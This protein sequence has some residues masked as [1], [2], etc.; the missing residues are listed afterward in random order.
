MIVAFI[1]VVTAL[2]A[3]IV[4]AA[5]RTGVLREKYAALW[6]LVAAGVLVLAIWPGL[7]SVV[8]DWFGVVVPSNLLFAVAILLL[9]AVSLQLSLAVSTLESHTRTL[10]EEVSLLR[11]DL[12]E[13]RREQ[14]DGTR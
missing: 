11:A 14:P 4:I 9:L 3:G 5:V 1:L 7:L 10:A 8:A 6:I 12:E 2:V 13:L